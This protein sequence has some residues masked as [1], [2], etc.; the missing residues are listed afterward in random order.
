MTSRCGTAFDVE[1]VDL[2][3]VDLPLLD[4]PEPPGEAATPRAH[5]A[6]EQDG[7][8][9]PA[10]VFVVPEYNHTTNAATRTRWLFGPGMARQAVGFIGYGGI[11]A[12][13]R[14]V[15]ALIPVVT[16]LA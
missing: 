16:A 9:R 13:A 8:R 12:G 11:A 10:Y 7:Q 4:E 15:Q 5:Q 2:A 3:E 14:A 1:L 6:L